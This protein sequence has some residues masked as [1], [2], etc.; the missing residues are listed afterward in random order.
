[1]VDADNRCSKASYLINRTEIVQ[2]EVNQKAVHAGSTPAI[3]TAYRV[4]Q[5]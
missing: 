5:K 3:V 4:H 2:L 1:M